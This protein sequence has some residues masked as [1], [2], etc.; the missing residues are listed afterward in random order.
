MSIRV[1][2]P[3]CQTVLNAPDAAAGK[4][5]RCPKCKKTLAIPAAGGPAGAQAKEPAPSRPAQPIAKAPPPLPA[6]GAAGKTP[7]KRKP[8]VGVY[9]AAIVVV[10]VLASAGVFL[11]RHLQG[12]GAGVASTRRS[13]SSGAPSSR[14]EGQAINRQSASG[15]R[16]AGRERDEAPEN[17]NQS[18]ALPSATGRQDATAIKKLLRRGTFTPDE[19]NEA[20]HHLAVRGE[21]E[22]TRE[23]QEAAEM[24][25]A[26]G[27]DI[28]GLRWGRDGGTSLHYRMSFFSGRRRVRAPADVL[29]RLGADVNARDKEGRTPLHYALREHHTRAGR[30]LREDVRFLIG[31]GADCNARDNE[32]RTPLHEACSKR[33]EMLPA[34]F[35]EYLIAE[36]ADVKAKDLR[37]YTPLHSVESVEKAR[38]VIDHGADTAAMNAALFVTRSLAVAQLLI[39]RGADV[40]ARDNAGG[41]PLHYVNSPE[42]AQLLIDKGADVNA[43]DKFDRTPLSEME[44]RRRM[45]AGE[46]YRKIAEIL[47]KHGATQ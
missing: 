39:E 21:G 41:T 46:P 12:S 29:V 45:P 17:T 36:G 28:E 5:G 7:G 37:G 1:S 9:C 15:M 16:A 20:L 25:V 33:E 43:R 10:V 44:R 6:S 13:S 35:V 42:V 8:P 34:A 38:I 18:V 47:K 24:L 23:Q 3:N 11:W 2:C 4:K 27:A 30:D 32:G 19:L 40:N 26:K 31:K 14:P 22:F